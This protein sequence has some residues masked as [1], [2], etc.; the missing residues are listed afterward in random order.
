MPHTWPSES[1][2]GIDA[3]KEIWSFINQ[4]DLSGKVD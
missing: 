1:N 2:Y 3:T 4:Y